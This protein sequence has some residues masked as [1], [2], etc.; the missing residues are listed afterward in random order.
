MSETP[1]IEEGSTFYWKC[2]GIDVHVRSL[3]V[4]EDGNTQLRVADG[5]ELRTLTVDDVRSRL[6][7]GVLVESQAE[8]I[9]EVAI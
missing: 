6:I 2:D 4:D 3:Y 7:S 8:T 9:T 1:V 5:A